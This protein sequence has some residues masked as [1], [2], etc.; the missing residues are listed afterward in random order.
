MKIENWFLIWAVNFILLLSILWDFN[1]FYFWTLNYLF[2]LIYFISNRM[3]LKILKKATTTKKKRNLKIFLQEKGTSKH[4]KTRRKASSR[5]GKKGRKKSMYTIS[6]MMALEN[7]EKIKENRCFSYLIF[8]SC[9]GYSFVYFYSIPRLPLG[10]CKHTN[11]I[12]Q[13]HFKTLR[14]QHTL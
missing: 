6:L 2:N 4:C 3:N 7:Q 13:I 1:E 12:L 10:F 5:K 14:I 11:K 9:F 8:K